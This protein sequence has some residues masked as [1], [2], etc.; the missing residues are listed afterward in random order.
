MAQ[1]LSKNDASESYKV[2]ADYAEQKAQREV[3]RRRQSRQ[4]SHGSNGDD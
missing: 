3:V 4:P 2:C 1:V